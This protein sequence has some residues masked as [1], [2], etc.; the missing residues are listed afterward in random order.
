MKLMEDCLLPFGDNVMHLLC[1][2]HENNFTITCQCIVKFLSGQFYPTNGVAFT[3]FG[4][5]T[6]SILMTRPYQDV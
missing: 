2:Y 6:D 3:L 5:E 1:V 4:P